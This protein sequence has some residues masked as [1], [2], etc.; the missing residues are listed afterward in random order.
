MKRSVVDMDNKKV[1]E[2]D[3][4]ED[5]FSVE[6]NQQCIYDAIK[7]SLANKR[8]G[9]HSVL[10][11]AEVNGSTRK[12]WRQKGTGR[13]RAGM[14]KSPLWEG[15]GVIFGPKPRDYSYRIPKKVK[16]KAYA[17]I[18]SQFLKDDKMLIVED[19][20]VSS[21]KTKEVLSILKNLVSSR[22][23]LFITMKREDRGYSNFLLSTRNIPWLKVVNVDSIEIKDLFYS[24]EILFEKSAIEKFNGGV[25][26]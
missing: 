8:Q 14:T 21:P 6:P 25:L 12:P 7:N 2:I 22:K 16:R 10:T 4:R 3:L 15:G 11:R 24:E 26:R 9:T 23:V 18:F 19:F 20:S 1:S 13:A 5:V 17:S